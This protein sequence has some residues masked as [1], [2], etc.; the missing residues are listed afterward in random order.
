LTGITA[1]HM[2][3]FVHGSGAN[4]KSTFVNALQHVFGDYAVVAPAETFAASHH[5]R[6]PTEV[7]ML[8]GARLV[9]ASETEEGR[10]WAEARVKALTGGDPI[11]ARF[12]RKDFFTFIPTFKLL[13]VGN[14]RPVLRNVDQAI[15]TSA[16]RCAPRGRASCDGRWMAA[17][18]GSAMAS[19][20]R[21]WFGPPRKSIW[22]IRTFSAPGPPNGSSSART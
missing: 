22:P 15:R 18:R 19:R 4:G 14:H 10:A 16:K 17:S 7:A 5:D 9:V 3:M 12:M 11:T 1:E 13:I 6:H 21:R 8:R 2:L 20:R